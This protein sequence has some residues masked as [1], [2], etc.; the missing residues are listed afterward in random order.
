MFYN[1]FVQNL[2]YEERGLWLLV[3]LGCKRELDQSY[4]S[5]GVVV[6]GRSPPGV[7]MMKMRRMV[8]IGHYRWSWDS[9]SG[10]GVVQMK[11]WW[12]GDGTGLDGC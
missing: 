2:S 6:C 8:L 12:T 3:L 9:P 11:L 5:L 10:P 1:Q 7:W 4:H